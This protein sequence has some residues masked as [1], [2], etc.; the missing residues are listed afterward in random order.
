MNN[1]RFLTVIAVILLA[2]SSVF[3]AGTLIVAPAKPTAGSKITLKYTADKKFAGADKLIAAYYI[4]NEQ[5]SQPTA[6]ES[7]L[8]FDKSSKSYSGSVVLPANTVFA[9]M[10]VGNGKTFDNSNENFFEQFIFTPSGTLVRSSSLRAAVSLFGSLPEP[11]RRRADLARARLLLTDEVRAY[12][13]NV[14]AQVGLLSLRFEA[15]EMQKEDYEAALQKT[16]DAG[17]DHSK[18]NEVRAVARTLK[19][20]NKADKATEIESEFTAKYPKSEYAEEIAISRLS[21]AKTEEEFVNTS[22]NFL[23]S[24]PSSSYYDRVAS[25]VIN[26]FIKKKNYSQLSTLFGEGSAAS[27]SA[28]T[29]IAGALGEVDSMLETAHEWSNRALA[30]ANSITDAS[31]PKFMTS[32]EWKENSRIA[33]GDANATNG[34]ILKRLNMNERALASFEKART[35][36]EEETPADV[37]E[38]ILETMD[39]MGKQQEALSLAD[40]AIRNSKA[41][42]NLLEQHKKLFDFVYHGTKNYDSSLARLKN[43]AQIER[44][45]KLASEKANLPPINGKITTLDGKEINLSDLKGKIVILDFWATWCGPC[46]ASFP[47]MQKLYE[48]YKN[49]PNIVFAIVD[50]WERVPDRRKAVSDFLA[51]NTNYTFPVYMDENDAVV[52]SFGVTGI[53]SKFF[54]G[55]SGAIQFKEVGFAGEEKFLEEAQD[56]IALLLEE[57]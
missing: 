20:L 19:L 14:Q 26:N 30:K 1:N 18:E 55:K 3:A 28:L 8:L 22:M 39:A 10:K 5:E 38:N 47:A 50:V 2:S 33:Q 11:C 16:I 43:N 12:P 40:E 57:N 23:K 52:K 51:K 45:K 29:Q 36:L 24:F 48:L 9:L 49:N 17:Y 44:R 31:R 53:P 54:I 32:S 25:S 46:R 41:S 35:L 15:K 37:Y 6:G 13:S 34:F 42:P 21:A 4:F 7:A 27:A 56:K